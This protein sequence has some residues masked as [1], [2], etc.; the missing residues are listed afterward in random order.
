MTWT[1]AQRAIL[2]G[3]VA[4]VAMTAV[5]YTAPM[6][7]MPRMDIAAM[8]GSLLSQGPPAAGSGPWWLGMMMHL[9]AG[10]VIFP[11]I[12][13]CVLHPVLP[14][15]PWLKGTVWGLILWLLAQVMVM[16]MMGV[17]FFSSRTPGAMMAV[18]GGL[19]GH[20]IYGVLLGA[21]ARDRW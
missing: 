7:G 9:I 14:G 12:Y 2:A 20:I 15:A 18:I 1:P 19:I 10:V 4:T 11:L 3:L 16:P 6:M 8:L 5:M 21:I 13:A 17:G